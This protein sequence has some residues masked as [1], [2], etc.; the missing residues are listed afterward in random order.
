V[1]EASLEIS[2]E[3]RSL[4]LAQD[5]FGNHVGIARFSGRSKELCFESVVRLEHSPLD[6]AD[7]DLGHAARTFRPR[8]RLSDEQWLCGPGGAKSPTSGFVD[9]SPLEGDGFEPSVPRK[10]LAQ[11]S[12]AP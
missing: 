11:A 8:D 10:I 6:P 7:L 3:P 12:A 2:P 9:D 1:I 4:H 5:T